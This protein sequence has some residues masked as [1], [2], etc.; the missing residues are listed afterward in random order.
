MTNPDDLRRDLARAREELQAAIQALAPKHVGGE[1]E[2]Y[3]AAAARCHALERALARSLDQEYGVPRDWP[4]RWDVGAPRPHVLSSGHLV[5]LVYLLSELDPNWDGSY[6]N[7]IDTEQPHELAVISF[8]RCT[9]YKF[10]GPNDEV[11]SGHPLYEK[12]L[13]PYRA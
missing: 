1:M 12:G 13:E 8:Q 5:R 9:I 4:L 10:G 11:L 2:R 6:V 3:Q 7:V